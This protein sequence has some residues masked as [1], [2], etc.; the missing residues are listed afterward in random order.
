[1]FLL[2]FGPLIGLLLGLISLALFGLGVWWVIGWF[3]GTITLTLFIVGIVMLVFTFLGR[4]LIL[5]F[6]GRSG[7]DDPKMAR[8]TETQR[9]KRPDGT[10]LQVEFFGPPDAQPLILTHG[11]GANSTDWYYAKQLLS[12]RFRLILWDVT[13]VGKSG[14]SATGD[15]SLDKMAS[16][17]EGVLGL[18]QKPAILIGHS[19]GG[20]ITLN[21]CKLF[22]Q[23]LGTRVAGLVLANTS[24]TNPLKTT[25]ARKL[26]TA[27]QK[28]LIQPL[29]YII[30]G[31][32]PLFWLMSWLS[33]LNG[34]SLIPNRIFTFSG[35]QTKGQVDFMALLQCLCSQGVLAK[36]MLGMLK[37][38]ATD[39]LPRINIPTLIIT[40][41]KDR[42]CIPEASYYMQQNIPNAKLVM[43]EPS[44]HGAMI[45]QNEQ[46]MAAVAEFSPTALAAPKESQ[47]AQG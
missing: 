35:H 5:L 37:Y 30:I 10:E 27:L 12:D 47:Q 3:T 13:G 1:M 19:M 45:E 8:S 41:N 28:P 31:L 24:Y 38:D 4:Y 18:A 33:Y 43:C 46:F 15:Y 39:T 14:R 22:P 29:M 36:Q 25:T 40:A 34:T 7:N 26:V 16:D 44:G 11:I 9:L 32:S 2:P 20:M 21:F 42:G 23:H 17:L 6:M